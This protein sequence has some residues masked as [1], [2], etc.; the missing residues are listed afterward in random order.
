MVE[1]TSWEVPGYY[2]KPD[3]MDMAYRWDGSPAAWT[4]KQVRD[5]RVELFIEGAARTLAIMGTF[6]ELARIMESAGWSNVFARE[7]FEEFI[8][9]HEEDISRR[10]DSIRKGGI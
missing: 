8:L 5:I 4:W 1:G 3:N 10:V 2:R 9:A 6:E 7:D